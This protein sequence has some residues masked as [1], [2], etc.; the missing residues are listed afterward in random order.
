MAFKVTQDCINCGVC[1]VECPAGAVYPPVSYKKKAAERMCPPDA[2][3]PVYGYS[4]YSDKHYYIVPAKCT[5]CRSYYDEPMC[6]LVCPVSG[7]IKLA[8]TGKPGKKYF[9][10]DVLCMN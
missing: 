3:F 2:D 7:I 8:F 9:C 4:F 6:V 10:G 1:E 5:E